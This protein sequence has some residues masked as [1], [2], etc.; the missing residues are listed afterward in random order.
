MKEKSNKLDLKGGGGDGIVLP[1]DIY[2]LCETTLQLVFFLLF[3]SLILYKVKK[4][5]SRELLIVLCAYFLC[6]V[7]R[8]TLNIVKVIK[9]VD[10]PNED[11]NFD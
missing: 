2:L 6:F 9:S 8:L 7:S 5:L 10:N 3:F 1:S 11:Y 4:E